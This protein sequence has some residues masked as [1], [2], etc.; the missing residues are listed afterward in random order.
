MKIVDLTHELRSESAPVL[1]KLDFHTNISE[2]R[3]LATHIEAPAYLMSEGKTLDQF[4]LQSFLRDAVLLDVSHMKHGQLIDDEDLEGAEEDAGLALREGEVV[5]IRTGWD[6]HGSSEDY[7]SDHPVLSENGAEYLEFK[8]VGGLGIDT[9]SID[10][11][12]NHELLA[13]SIL[14]RN[15]M[16]VLE[17][18]C[19]LDQVDE[20]RFRLI[21]LP[22]R[23]KAAASLV[24]AVALLGETA[25]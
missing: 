2:N 4:D 15:E 12:S 11:A 16:F 14:F 5:I 18:L 10:P 23:I 21:A 17:N 19:N 7:W 13:H 8:R 20:E 3:F 1:D 22:L 25:E 6:K 24:R 9:A